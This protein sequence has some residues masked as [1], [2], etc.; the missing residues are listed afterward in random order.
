MKENVSETK[1]ALHMCN[2]LYIA[3]PKNKNH[4][5]IINVN[6]KIII[7]ISLMQ[8]YR[9]NVLTKF[10]T[11]LTNTLIDILYYQKETAICICHIVLKFSQQI[12]LWHKNKIQTWE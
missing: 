11:S 10:C 4:F 3:S 8:L 7:I 6:D 2:I 12:C 9:S 5:S 1:I